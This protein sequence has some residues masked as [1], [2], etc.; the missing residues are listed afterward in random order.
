M[1]AYLLVHLF[2]TGAVQATQGE[3]VCFTVSLLRRAEQMH[4]FIVST[5]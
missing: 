5:I 4:Y 2:V 3:S 1:L